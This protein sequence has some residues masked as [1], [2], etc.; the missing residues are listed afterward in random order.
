MS[1][2]QV[3]AHGVHTESRV[4]SLRDRRQR[5]VITSYLGRAIEGLISRSR[6]ARSGSIIE[7]PDCLQGK[8]RMLASRELPLVEVVQN[9]WN[10]RELAGVDLWPLK[11][12]GTNFTC[13][14]IRVQG[15][16]G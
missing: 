4:I 11:G 9:R 2:V 5:V 6:A 16:R 10:Y 7:A 3:R 14:R 15:W 8:V 13:R 1:V 12:C